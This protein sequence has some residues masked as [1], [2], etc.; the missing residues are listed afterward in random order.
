MDFN[1][2]LG[3]DFSGLLDVQSSLGVVSGPRAMLE[4]IG[5]RLTTLRGGLWYD[6]DY[7]YDLRQH[8]NAPAPRPGVIESQV[9]AEV[10]KDERVQDVDA[11]VVATRDAITVTLRIMSDIG[12]FSLI[13]AVTQLTVTLLT[14]NT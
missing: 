7:G 2:A 1:D 13:V 6:P 4:A 9:V 10:L 3:S 11:S 14:D 12:P 8:L 5:R